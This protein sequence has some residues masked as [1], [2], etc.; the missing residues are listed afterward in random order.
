MT[1]QEQPNQVVVDGWGVFPLS[2]VD[3]LSGREVL[4]AQKVLGTRQWDEPALEVG[5]A[6][7][8][9]AMRRVDN[10]LTLD[11]FLAIPLGAFDFKK[12]ETNGHPL[13][14]TPTGTESAGD[15]TGQP[16]SA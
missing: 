6:L 8:Y 16:S 13:S 7:A 5:L 4:E 12:A 3:D 2:T 10:R 9:I 11:D 14:P 15:Q 1:E